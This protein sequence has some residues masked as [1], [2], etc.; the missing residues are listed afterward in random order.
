[1]DN[2][3]F[4]VDLSYLK[5]VASGSDEFIIDMIDLFLNQT[6]DYFE[7][8]EQ[9]IAE[10]NWTKVADIA[11]KIKP[12][13]AFMG[14]DSAREKMAE[15]EQNARDIKNLG[16]ISPAFQILKEMSVE[17]YKQ[18]DEVKASLQNPT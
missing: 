13:L 7:Q 15:I 2:S 1:M 4:K 14:V 6:P 11:H 9:F 5:D 10:E 16:T 8:L 17:L 12:T 18:L 3:G